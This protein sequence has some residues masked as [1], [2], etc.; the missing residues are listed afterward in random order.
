MEEKPLRYVYDLLNLKPYE[1]FL[2][3]EFITKYRFLPDGNRQWHNDLN[4]TWIVDNDELQLIRIIQNPNLIK[5]INSN[6]FIY[7]L[8][9]DLTKYDIIILK[10]LVEV[11]GPIN[12]ILKVYIDGEKYGCKI[13]FRKNVN[14][15]YFSRF[16]FDFFDKIVNCEKFEV[17]GSE[18]SA[19]RLCIK[20]VKNYEKSI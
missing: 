15:V 20:G 11:Y 1:E 2:I 17:I 9:E 13:M 6:P 7:L 12:H 4:N 10:G 3:G 19:W 18:D 16:W 8:D 14:Y 5:K